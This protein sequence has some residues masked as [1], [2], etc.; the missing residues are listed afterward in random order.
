MS[1]GDAA[2]V[3]DGFDDVAGAGFPLRADHA[4]TLAD[5][6]EGLAEIGGAT[7]ERDGERELVDV[8]GLVGRGQHLGLVDVVDP[9]GLQDL[10]LDEVTDPGLGHDGDRAD[11]LDALDH[12]GVAHPGDAAVSTDVGRNP[13]EG[14]H[15]RCAGVFGDL[16]LLGVDDVHDDATLEHF[17]QAPLHPDR[18]EVGVVVRCFAHGTILRSPGKVASTQQATLSL[19]GPDPTARRP[20]TGPTAGACRPP[21]GRKPRSDLGSAG[22]GCRRDRAASAEPAHRRDSR[23]PRSRDR[24]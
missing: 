11:G 1:S 6:T 21:R 2:Q 13:L 4:G 22:S 17:G 10:G 19:L 12:L 5:A 15:R 9:Q 23:S 20:R 3:P 14:H 8:V 24:R 16:C 7:D 18:A